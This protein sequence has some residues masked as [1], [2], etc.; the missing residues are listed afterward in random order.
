MFFSKNSF[1]I[2]NFILF[3]FF[4]YEKMN[5]N[6]EYVVLHEKNTKCVF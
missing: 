2:S 4:N 1:S 5:F 6:F 3:Y